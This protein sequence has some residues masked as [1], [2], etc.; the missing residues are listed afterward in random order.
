MKC[1]Y[2]CLEQS[3]DGEGNTYGDLVQAVL[4]RFEL[5]PQTFNILEWDLYGTVINLSESI[6]FL[7]FFPGRIR[8]RKDP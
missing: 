2:I 6:H 7:L 4:E 3:V 5:R 1:V 8:L